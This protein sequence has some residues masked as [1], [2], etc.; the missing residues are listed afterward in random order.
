M[1]WKLPVLPFGDHLI[2]KG[3]AFHES[4]VTLADNQIGIVFFKRLQKFVDGCKDV[5]AF[6]FEIDLGLA[7]N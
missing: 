6:I 7:G 2:R 5:R 4:M 3:R 1:P